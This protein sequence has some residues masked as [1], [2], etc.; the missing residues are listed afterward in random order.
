MQIH[1]GATLNHAESPVLLANRG[2]ISWM[3]MKYRVLIVQFSETRHPPLSV[4][5][6]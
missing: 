5:L 4:F 3:G 6:Q 1:A 2:P